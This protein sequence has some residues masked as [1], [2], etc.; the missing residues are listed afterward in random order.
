MNKIST[1]LRQ[2]QKAIPKQILQSRFL[3]M[4]ISDIEEELQNEIEKNPVLVEKDIEDFRE[5]SQDPSQFDNQENYDFFLANLAE[6]IDVVGS[7]IQQI[8]ESDMNSRDKEIAKQIIF[9]VDENGFLDI[10]P[11]LIADHCKADLSEVENMINVVK[12]LN[13]SG[14]GCKDIQ[15]YLLFQIDEKDYLAR[16][17]IMEHF[18]DFLQQDFL[19]IKS[20]L[21]CSD[22][23][24]DTA[25][26]I[27]S[28]KNFSPIVSHSESDYVVPDLII[29]LKDEKWIILVNDKNLTKFKIAN[30]YLDEAMM[31]K[32]SDKEKK[33][34][35]DHI[36]N[37]QN[38][39][40]AI[41][42]RSTTLKDVMQEIVILQ[43]DYLSENQEYPNPLRLEDI[44]E[45]LEVDISTISRAIKDKYV[46]TPL[47]VISLKTFFSSKVVK[48]SGEIIGKEELKDII[49]ELID[50]EDKTN[51]LSDLEIS[52]LLKEQ[53]IS[54]A[55]R[56]VAKYRESMNIPNVKRRKQSEH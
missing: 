16:K 40:D 13:P 14:V 33:F 37:A 34:I 52:N 47:G 10:E 54:I 44:A 6:D 32:F 12:N 38:L 11:E 21:N 23:E 56:T 36:D 5:K 28:S 41:V 24:F 49:R 26:D 35:N 3:E 25:L 20:N 30:D 15:E 27:I 4:S 42:F 46:D 7:L 55:R 39:L 8:E 31:Q 2:K 17:I 48:D 53:N 1:K 51:P 22:S 9:N 50:S 29:R 43:N 45:K 19:K 18:H